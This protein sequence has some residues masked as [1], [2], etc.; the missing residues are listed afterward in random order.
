MTPGTAEAT[1]L[2]T[3]PSPHT[4]HTTNQVVALPATTIHSRDHVGAS[5]RV[6]CGPPSGLSTA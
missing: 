1:A 5:R 6:D 2:K 4:C 3:L